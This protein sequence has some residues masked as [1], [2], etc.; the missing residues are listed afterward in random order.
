MHIGDVCSHEVVTIMSR[1]SALVAARRLAEGGIDALVVVEEANPAAAVGFL[2]DRDL[3]RG[4]LAQ[5]ASADL[6]PVVDLMRPGAATCRETDSLV[7]A[8]R[9]MTQFGSG[10]LVVQ[11]LEGGIVGVVTARDVQA[12]L[13]AC[14]VQM[15][16]AV[17]CQEAVESRRP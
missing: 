6:T 12:A 2:T 1:E 16:R 3:V 15:D 8:A 9:R 5:G 17:R 7:A 4:V 13:N 10:R 14:I 11:G